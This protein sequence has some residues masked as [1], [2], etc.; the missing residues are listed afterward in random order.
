MQSLGEKIR[1]LRSALKM[2]QKDLAEKLEI[3]IKSIQR[4]ETGKS[5]PDT[6]SLVKLATFFDVSSDYLLGLTSLMDQMAER[7][8]KLSKY[9]RIFYKNYIK[10]KNDYKIYSDEKYYWIEA[11]DD[12]I[13]G[14]TMWE[15]FT[16]DSI[17][18][19][20]R[21]LRPVI[22][23]KAIEICTQTCGKPMVL[24]TEEDACTFLMFGGQAIVRE[25]ICEKYLPWFLEPF[26]VEA[27]SIL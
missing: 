18:K 26:V 20:I 23:E 14:Q 19:E 24:N 6:Y 27:G 15:G 16:D 5:R 2:T 8:S 1:D 11:K 10:C 25:E 7:E 12:K 21:V 3:D 4:Y 13:G 9:R 22:P 17:P